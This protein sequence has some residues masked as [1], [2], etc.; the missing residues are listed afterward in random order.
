MGRSPAKLYHRKGRPACHSGCM[1]TEHKHNHTWPRPPF[2]PLYWVG[3]VIKALS[4]SSAA[5]SSPRGW[6][7]QSGSLLSPEVAPEPGKSIL[8]ILNGILYYKQKSLLH[9]GNAENKPPL[10]GSCG[11]R[12]VSLMLVDT[13]HGIR[14]KMWRR[15]TSPKAECVPITYKA[16]GLIPGNTHLGNY[17]QF[18]RKREKRASPERWFRD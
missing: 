17:Q 16:L 2:L 1:Y 3:S 4:S 18:Y 12:A 7:A 8:E 10:Y 6:S 13:T 11:W 14:M 9:V 5:V 15:E